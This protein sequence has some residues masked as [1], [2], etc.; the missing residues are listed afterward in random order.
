[1]RASVRVVAVVSRL[2]VVLVTVAVV[3]HRK[4]RVTM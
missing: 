2:V 1:V 3:M 4:W